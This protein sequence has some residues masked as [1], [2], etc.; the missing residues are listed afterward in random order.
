MSELELKWACKSA[1]EAAML[2][3]VLL[4]EV[5]HALRFGEGHASFAGHRLKVRRLQTTPSLL[6]VQ[7]CGDR[8]VEACGLWRASV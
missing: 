7:V 4:G 1:S 8:G 5:S 2:S 6:W 3:S